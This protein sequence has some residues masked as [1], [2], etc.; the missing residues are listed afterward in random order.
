MEVDP[1]YRRRG[2]GTAVLAALAGV[3]RDEGAERL[4]LQVDETNAAGRALYARA[5]FVARYRYHYRLAPVT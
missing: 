2:L 5:G 3:A 1:A 4:Y